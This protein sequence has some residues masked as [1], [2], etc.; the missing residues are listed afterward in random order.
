MENGISLTKHNQIQKLSL[1]AP[2]STRKNLLLVQLVVNYTEYLLKIYL[3]YYTLMHMQDLLMIYTL[4]QKD[5]INLLALMK[6]ELVKS[7]TYQSTNVYFKDCLEGRSKDQAV[8]L[9]QMT[10]Q[11]LLV[12]KTVSLEP[13]KEPMAIKYGKLLMLIEDQLLLSMQMPI[14]F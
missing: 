2:R 8:A 3:T 9:H 14:I 1:C 7:G 6:T 13:L 12:G 11:S 5:Q 4:V 10:T